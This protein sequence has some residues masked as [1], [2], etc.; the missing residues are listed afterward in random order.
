[1]TKKQLIRALQKSEAP[2]NAEV[3]IAVWRAGDISHDI[4]QFDLNEE[5]GEDK[6]W[7]DAQTES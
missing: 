4:K 1:M 7:I 5:P 6:L 3:H 2:D